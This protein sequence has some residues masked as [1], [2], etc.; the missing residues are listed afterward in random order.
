LIFPFIRA[1]LGAEEVE[2]RVSFTFNRF[3]LASIAL[4]PRCAKVFEYEKWARLDRIGHTS[5]AIPL[6]PEMIPCP[7]K[8][9]SQSITWRCVVSPGHIDPYKDL[10]SRHPCVEGVL[11]ALTN[12]RLSWIADRLVLKEP[13]LNGFAD[14]VDRPQWREMPRF[15]DPCLQVHRFSD[16]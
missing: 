12:Q 10:F 7:L 8:I 3:I 9:G 15:H 14:L 6:C 13:A 16:A 4:Q 2:E 5:K 11:D 1:A